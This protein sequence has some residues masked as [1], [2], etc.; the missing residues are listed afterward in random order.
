MVTA[1]TQPRSVALFVRS[2]SPSASP[3]ARHAEWV[4]ALEA[5][6]RVAEA[7]V[8]VW[9]SEVELSARARR[10]PAGKCVLDR[11]AAFR[12]WADERG[13]SMAPFFDTRAVSASLTGEEYTA[14]RLP[15]T[16]LAEYED[17]E[18]VHVAP[19]S[20][21]EAI[22][23]VAD[24]LRRLDRAAGVDEDRGDGT[25]LAERPTDGP[26]TGSAADATVPTVRTP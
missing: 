16:C 20:T 21:G 15:V 14:L 4:R 2:L 24:R 18:L 17:E 1:S 13:V 11:V 5:G 12:A 6:G 22:C 23:S 19:Y 26:A 10:T 7:S 8:A 3:A 9:G 25:A